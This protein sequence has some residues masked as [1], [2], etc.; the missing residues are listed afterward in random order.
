MADSASSGE[1]PP[2][3]ARPVTVSEF[4]AHLAEMIGRAERGEEVVISRGTRP[5]AKLVPL[6]R[7][8][9]RRLGGLRGLMSDRDLAALVAT[10][11]GPLTPRDRAAL[12][13]KETDLAGIS[14]R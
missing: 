13:G 4:R 11:E 10:I 14:R 3:P 9:R 6:G 2:T 8:R 1:M 5:V 7:R 12:E